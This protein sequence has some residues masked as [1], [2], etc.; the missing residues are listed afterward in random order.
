M[1]LRNLDIRTVASFGQEWSTYDQSTLPQDAKTEQ[2]FQ[3]YFAIFPWDGLPDHAVGAD[4]GCGSGR[5]AVRVAPRVGTLHCIDASADALEV[6][7]RNLVGQ[8]NCMLHHASVGAM[9]LAPRSLDFCYSLGVLHHVPDTQAA[10]RNCVD[11]LKPGSPFLLYLYYALDQR[12]WWYRGIWRGSDLVRRGIARLPFGP[13]RA[14]TELIALSVYWPMARLCR[15]LTA[16]GIDASSLPLSWYSDKSL[17]IM[18]TNAFDRF[19]TPLE[20]RF[21]KTQI[22]TMMQA[23]GLEDIRF[24]EN[25]PFWCAVGRR[26]T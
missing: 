9:P 22:A 2:R 24:S 16:L 15:G 5:W 6:A 12:P 19:A 7:R 26:G 17:Y 8:P 4:V 14:L 25:P 1:E 10:I 20:Q 11:L 13:K 21:S 3:E 23:A 18:R